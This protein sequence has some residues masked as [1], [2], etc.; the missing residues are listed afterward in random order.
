MTR[1]RASSAAV[2]MRT[3]EASSSDHAC[4]FAIARDQRGDPLRNLRT[5]SGH[6]PMPGHCPFA[7]I[8][9]DPM[10]RADGRRPDSHLLRRLQRSSQR[11][12]RGRIAA[13]AAARD[14]ARDRVGAAGGGEL[15]GFFGGRRRQFIRDLN[16]DDALR[17]SR[18]GVELAEEAKFIAQA[19]DSLASSTWAGIVANASELDARAIV[20]GSRGLAGARARLEG[21][22]S[23][24][25]AEHEGRPVLIVLSQWA[26]GNRGRER[27]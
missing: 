24:A 5:R 25:I 26:D 22:V 16:A 19:R 6:R 12:Q 8:P 11:D 13:E 10:R 20:I 3:R 15:R 14:R 4:T 18:A 7:T 27:S 17:R 2:T 21:K 9:P 1:R 23:H